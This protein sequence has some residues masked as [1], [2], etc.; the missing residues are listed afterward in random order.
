MFTKHVFSVIIKVTSILKNT[1]YISITYHTYL[2]KNI[3]EFMIGGQKS[4]FEN[5]TTK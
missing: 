1:Y 2:E 4:L 3:Y 5:D